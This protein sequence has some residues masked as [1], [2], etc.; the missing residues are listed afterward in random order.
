MTALPKGD[1][2]TTTEDDSGVTAR[3]ERDFSSFRTSFHSL[4]AHF[5]VRCTR[6]PIQELALNPLL[7]LPLIVCYLHV[8]VL[9]KHVLKS[10]K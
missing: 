7:W 3:K 1:T 5:S 2:G 8:S 10:P 9:K 6:Q 4:S